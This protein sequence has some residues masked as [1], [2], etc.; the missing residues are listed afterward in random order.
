M[1]LHP[2]LTPEPDDVVVELAMTN[3][4]DGCWWVTPW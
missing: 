1:A 4:G 2:L 3:L